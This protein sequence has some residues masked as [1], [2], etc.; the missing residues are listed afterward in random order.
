M[1]INSNSNPS[2]AMPERSVSSSNDAEGQGIS[3]HSTPKVKFTHFLWRKKN[4]FSSVGLYIEAFLPDP[5]HLLI[6]AVRPSQI[7]GMRPFMAG[8]EYPVHGWHRLTMDD[9][10][11]PALE[12]P[13]GTITTADICSSFP[14]SEDHWMC[15]PAKFFL[16]T[17]PSLRL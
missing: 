2:F 1:I 16:M 7:P 4:V 11:S 13:G 8:H 6:V 14:A 17:R 15:L 9:L 3:T 12:F 10:I 5:P